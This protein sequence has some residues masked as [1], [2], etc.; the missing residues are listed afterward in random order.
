ML[1]SGD[2]V[3]RRNLAEGGGRSPGQQVPKRY[4]VGQRV[5]KSAEI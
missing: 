3:G 4:P 5:W 2:E 1:V